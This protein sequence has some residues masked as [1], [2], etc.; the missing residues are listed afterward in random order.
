MGN[1]WST[2]TGTDATHDG[3]G[4]VPFTMYDNETDTRPLV[5]PIA[6]YLDENPY[7]GSDDP[8]AD[9]ATAPALSAGQSATLTFTGSAVQSVTITAAEGTGRI[10]LTVDPAPRGPDGLTGPV[11][12]YITAEISGISDDGISEAEFS[13]R[14]PAAWLRAEG[15]LPVDIALWR[16]HDNAWQELPATIIRE[17]NGWVYFTATTPG[18]SSFAIAGGAI[19]NLLMETDAAQSNTDAETETT[20]D[21]V[22]ITTEPVNETTTEPQVTVA[23]PEDEGTRTPTDTA[24]PQESPL[25]IITLIGGAAGAALIFRKR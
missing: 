3:I 4:D 25:G 10:L 15:M 22:S 2:Y 8:S 9:M 18:F 6:W 20:H 21:T 16:F 14:V 1:Y 17:E 5:S 7:S 19:E 12:Q 23:V 11:Y 24:T 13:F